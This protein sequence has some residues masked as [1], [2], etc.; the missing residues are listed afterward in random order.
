MLSMRLSV[1]GLPERTWAGGVDMKRR[2][3]CCGMF[4]CYIRK[5]FGF[6]VRRMTMTE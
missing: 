1:L 5:F 3:L 4:M 6:I 2:A